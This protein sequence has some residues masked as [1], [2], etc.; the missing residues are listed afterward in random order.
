MDPDGRGG[1]S[2]RAFDGKI[3]K[4][5]YDFNYVVLDIGGD[6]KIPMH[7]TM[8]VA[9]HQEYICQVRVTKIYKSFAVA[10]I[11]PDMKKGDPIPNDRVV[12]LPA[13]S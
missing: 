3:T 8:T 4:I 7:L 12:Y 13:G 1:N 11:L 6:K 2:N 9:R 10:E 5:N